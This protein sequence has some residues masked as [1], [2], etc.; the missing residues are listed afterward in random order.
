M[1][2]EAAGLAKQ[3]CDAAPTAPEHLEL[4]AL[5][6]AASGDFKSA[7]TVASQALSLA[8]SQGKAEMAARIEARLKAYQSRLSG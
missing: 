3:C 1:I 2:Q 6:M 4:L 5:C 7:A 8:Q